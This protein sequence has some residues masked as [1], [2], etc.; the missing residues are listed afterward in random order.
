VNRER[1]DR[2]C[3]WAI[4]GLVLAI[5]V[6]GPLAFGAVRASEFVV[7]QWLLVATV[8]VWLIRLWVG[9]KYRFLMPP[10]A[11]AVLPFVAYA[12]WRYRVADVEYIARQEF[13]QV[14]MAAVIFLIIVN[15]LYGQSE[16]RILTSSLVILGMLV[17]MYGIYQ[18]LTG[19][20]KVWGLMRPGYEGRGSGSFVC[21]NH[22]AGF[23][24]MICP[25]AITFMVLRGFGAVARI[26][27]AYAAFVMLVGIATTESRGGWVAIGTALAVLA[28]VLI[29]KQNYR[30]TALALLL[31]LGVTGAWLYPRSLEQRMPHVIS[32]PEAGDV[33]VR[34]WESARKMWL[35]H[36]WTGVGPAHFDYRYRNYRPAYWAVQERP[37]YAHND[38]WNTLADWGALGLI[39]ILVPVVTAGAGLFFSWRYLQRGGETPGNRVAVVL[40]CAIGLLAI[41]V[42]SFFDFNMHIPANAFLAAALLAI[43][44]AHW[45]FAS[46]RF[47]LTAR[48]PARVSATLILLGAIYYL[49]TQTLRHTREA[50]ALHTADK[51]RPA[52]SA[53]VAALKEAFAAEPRN[54]ETAY[55][56]GEDLRLRSSI[57]G[58]DYQ[59]LALEAVD[60]FKRAI[61][62]NR[63]DP[64]PC[65][66]AGMALDWIDRHAEA[67]AYFQRALELDPNHARTI[68]MMGWHF[69]QMDDFAEARRWF[70]RS[71]EIE[72]AHI[73]P[74]AATYANLTDKMLAEQTNGSALFPRR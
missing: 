6:F 72:G 43:M 13:I 74:F 28:A 26:C 32:Y 11:W 36:P 53:R 20:Q 9:P 56:V 35:D 5:L 41:L 34:I 42:H 50:R 3:E 1:I 46:Q 64:A 23:L 60:W 68:A 29:R 48:W 66:R 16:L 8:A 18:W 62:L 59:A 69:F 55:L 24:E 10:S 58:D 45:R 71:L 4:M 51:A 22:L 25:L 61:E 30:W 12:V 27:F 40:G 19:G 63:W 33:R 37:G 31:V 39:L 49:G 7:L 2:F 67:R 17:A 47:W 14:V 15:N 65:L 54:S 44:A 70:N 73:N 21:P 38:Y 57:G 52:S